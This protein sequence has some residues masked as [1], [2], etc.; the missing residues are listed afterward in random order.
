MAF[1]VTVCIDTQRG[2]MATVRVSYALINVVTSTVITT[3]VARFAFTLKAALTIDARLSMCVACVV[4]DSAFVDITFARPPR[5]SLTTRA[6]ARRT[7]LAAMQTH[8]IAYGWGQLN[9]IID[10]TEIKVS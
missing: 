10:F 6:D 1:K 2:R 8:G 3:L 9:S 4:A 7:T 5:K